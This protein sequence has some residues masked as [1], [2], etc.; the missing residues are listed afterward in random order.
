MTP[1]PK[2]KIKVDV[3]L[4]NGEEEPEE[5]A[6]PASTQRDEATTAV[7]ISKD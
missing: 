5:G 6:A 4:R 3:V 7:V 2:I 1:S